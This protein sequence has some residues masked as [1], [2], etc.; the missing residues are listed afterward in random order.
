MSFMLLLLCAVT[1][2]RG[3]V[4]RDELTLWR[5]TV[6]KSPGKARVH[7]GL[8]DALKKAGALEEAQLHLE[9]VLEIQP[10]HIDALGNLATLYCT[11]GRENECFEL[12]QRAL[13]LDSNYL[14]TRY[15]LGLY[16]YQKG[17]FEDAIEEFD[18][19][20][21]IEPRS[22]EAVFSGQMLIMIQNER[23]RH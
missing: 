8:G 4:Y 17:L 22:K 6:L 5:D 7:Y 12:L 21:R 2:L 16:Y 3:S 9:R 18:A 1:W 14:Y 19:V 13:S 15:K 23:I 10:D 20:I 11:T